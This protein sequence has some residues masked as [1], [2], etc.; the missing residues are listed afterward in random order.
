MLSKDQDQRVGKDDVWSSIAI[1]PRCFCSIRIV[2]P[3]HSVS[4]FAVSARTPVAIFEVRSARQR[5][6][7]QVVHLLLQWSKRQRELDSGYFGYHLGVRS[8]K[9]VELLVKS[10]GHRCFAGG[11]PS[12][13][14]IRGVMMCW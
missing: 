9:N 7:I 5:F 8:I 4:L 10:I 1:C 13:L 2:E 3:H 12:P 6:A 14:G 11:E